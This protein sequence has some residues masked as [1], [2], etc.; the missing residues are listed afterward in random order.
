MSEW[1]KEHAWKA[2][3]ASGTKRFQSTLTYTRSV[4]SPA[5]TITRCASVNLDVLRGLEADVSQSYHNRV[6]HLPRVARYAWVLVQWPALLTKKSN[7]STPRLERL[8][9][10]PKLPAVSIRLLRV[11]RSPEPL[12]TGTTQT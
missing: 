12:N 8:P 3:P 1:L 7:R 2:K 9:D 5:K 4:T 10:L 11:Q 6:A